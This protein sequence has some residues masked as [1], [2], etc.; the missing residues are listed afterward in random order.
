[1]CAVAML[2]ASVMSYAP[3]TEFFQAV[4]TFVPLVGIGGFA[5]LAYRL[6]RLPEDHALQ[7]SSWLKS[8]LMLVVLLLATMFIG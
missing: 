2:A 6:G 4:M 3:G 1:M 8:I 7:Q 5:L